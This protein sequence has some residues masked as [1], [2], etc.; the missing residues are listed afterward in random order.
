MI[1]VRRGRH[2]SLP[3]HNR[4]STRTTLLSGSTVV[5]L[6]DDEPQCYKNVGRVF[7]S[8]KSWD[9]SSLPAVEEGWE[10]GT[11]PRWQQLEGREGG[12]RRRHESSLAAVV[13]G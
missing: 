10:G 1:V 12:S 6:R 13:A 2:V 3:V 11:S 8:N 9:E 4:R 5:W 7:A